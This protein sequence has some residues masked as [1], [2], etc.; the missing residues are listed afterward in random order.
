MLVSGASSPWREGG[1][2]GIE[3]EMEWDGRT[4]LVID[5]Q[6][7][8]ELHNRRILFYY[9]YLVFCFDLWF[10]SETYRTSDAAPQIHSGEIDPQLDPFILCTLLALLWLITRRV[11][12]ITYL[13]NSF[14]A[15]I[16]YLS[17]HMCHPCTIY[18]CKGVRCRPMWN[19]Y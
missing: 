7:A 17:S 3:N 10:Y 15:L 6:H 14:V 4:M 5:M 1:D 12:I 18:I 13:I 11:I 19:R 9:Y 2:G 16:I 8:G